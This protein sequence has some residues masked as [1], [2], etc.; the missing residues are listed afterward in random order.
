MERLRNLTVQARLALMILLFF[1]Q[2][3]VLGVLQYT[4]REEVQVNGPLYQKI[5][6]GKDLLAD[7]LPPPLFLVETFLDAFEMASEPDR[8]RLEALIRRSRALRREYEE[9]I[10][11]WKKLPEGPIRQ[12]LLVESHRP[13]IEFLDLLDREFVPAVR[14]GDR[15]RARALL[16]GPM[17]SLYDQHR[18]AVDRLVQLT[19]AENKRIETHV[20]ETLAT[21]QNYMLLLLALCLIITVA[22]GV[23]MYRWLAGT[24]GEAVNTLSTT[25]VEI[26]SA[27]EQHERT[28]MTQAAA[29]NETTATMD[30]L[31]ASFSHTAAIVRTA[32]ETANES[33]G[34][35]NQGIK[36]VQQTLH[37]MLGLKEKVGAIADQILRLSEHTS[38]IGT[39]SDV[40]GD[41]AS[42]T[43]MLALNAAVE[44]AR[45]GEH[46]RGFAVVAA[47]IRKL[48]DESR[49]SAE[50]IRTLVGEIQK[51][52]NSTVMATE[53]GTKTVEK[54]ICLAEETVAAFNKVAETSQAAS[55]AA[56]QT[57]LSVPQQATAVK[58][59]LESMD[60]LNTGAQETANGIGQTREGI[61][62]LREAVLKLK[63]LT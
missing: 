56:Q 26:A 22:V 52:T 63:A 60:S 59:V 46:G 15:A 54:G 47:E 18:R 61:E 49:K 5:V 12:T 33:L 50:R 2:V 51:S 40:V 45:A 24:L 13:A 44:A 57:L 58:Q 62:H 38:Q 3:V 23:L 10:D 4:K 19:T 8:A 53:D 34:V 9:R 21:Y 31:D 7:V 29:V 37:G 16:T 30:E 35:A 48:A 1:T 55:E 20:R 36:T 42:Q 25:S 17:R 32:A 27:I 41:L 39:I 11:Y 14:S 43:N 6:D 28:A